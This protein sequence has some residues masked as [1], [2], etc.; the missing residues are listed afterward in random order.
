M[1]QINYIDAPDGAQEKMIV[2]AENGNPVSTP[3]SVAYGVQDI[4]WATLEP[5]VWKLD[6]TMRIM[7]DDINPG[8]WSAERSGPDGY[9]INPPKITIA[10]PVPYAA[11]GF[12][13]TFSPATNQWCTEIHARWYSGQVL[14][15]DK[16][17]FPSSPTWVMEEVVSSF[18]KLEVE[19]LRTNVPGQFAKVQRV[20]VG[21]TV[22]FD[23]GDIKTVRLVNE[24][25]PTLCELTVDTLSFDMHDSERRSFLP[26]ENQRI[27]LMENGKIRAVQ[28]ITSSTRKSAS[29][30]TIQCQS[31]IG[32]LTG[33]YL[34][35]MYNGVPA[36]GL[37]ADVL[38]TWEYEIDSIFS[39]TTISGY[40]PVCT[41]REAIQQIAFA[42][43]AIV[44][45]Q[46]TSKI[47][48]VPV[49]K[50]ISARF[51]DND[52]ILGGNVKTAPRYARV[53]IVSHTYTKSDETERLIDEEAV[54]GDDVLFTFTTPHYDYTIT[55]GEIKES[56]VNWVRVSADGM[57]S[58]DAKIY[59][60]NERT[61][62][63][64]NPEATAREQGN[65]YSITKATLIN[66]LNAQETLD[67]LYAAVQRRQTVNQDVIVSRQRAGQ[68]AS[69]LTPWGTITTGLISSMDCTIT[70]TGQ[71]ATIQ[72]QGI[73]VTLESVYP[74]SGEIYSGGMEVL[75]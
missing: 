69:S 35:G 47:R 73:E 62:T 38:G 51:R 75:Y 33:E 14:V 37:I 9:F 28:Y 2:S 17:Y 56:G 29:D 49:P 4:P 67:R 54:S 55:G 64:R 6:G 1:I 52:I 5:G 25:D 61:H 19:L 45:T 70:Q 3:G 71:I 44:T 11:T 59:N 39:G 68:L 31:A 43:G 41:Q 36:E 21:R 74:Y 65:A 48:F 26:Q 53:D 7:P 63:K 8:F 22:L 24:T 15:I 57:I 72:I 30:Y 32:L 12:T 13:F 60:H 18:D 50:I 16:T 34:G 58:I 23:A 10:F 46:E 40:L 42:I 27:E 66:S 20:E